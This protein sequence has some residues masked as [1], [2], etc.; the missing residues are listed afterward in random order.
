MKIAEG[1]VQAGTVARAAP[2]WTQVGGPRNAASQAQ[3]QA[4]AALT[5]GCQYCRSQASVTAPPWS[6]SLLG[7]KLGAFC[8]ISITCWASSVL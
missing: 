6:A 3:I 4:P 1:P 7:E 5:Q 8:A 2:E